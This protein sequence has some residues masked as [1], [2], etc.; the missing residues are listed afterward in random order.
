MKKYAEGAEQ[1]S[2]TVYQQYDSLQP[3]IDKLKLEKRTATVATRSRHPAPAARWHRKSCW[4]IRVRQRGGEEQ[5]QHRC[6]GG[7]APTS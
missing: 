4:A 1:F 3:V 5:A 7:R 2:E 6:R